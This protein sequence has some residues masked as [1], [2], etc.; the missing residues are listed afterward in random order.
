M[1]FLVEDNVPHR[2]VDKMMDKVLSASTNDPNRSIGR[3]ES[4][5]HQEYVSAS[6]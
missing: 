3:R 1:C 2:T 6:P 5:L 4:K